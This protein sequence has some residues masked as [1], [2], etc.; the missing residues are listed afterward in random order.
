MLS[1]RAED[2]AI[3]AGRTFTEIA[4]PILS[5]EILRSL[6]SLRMT[7]GSERLP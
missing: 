1:L 2:V 6:R 3:S 4:G 7:G 5:G